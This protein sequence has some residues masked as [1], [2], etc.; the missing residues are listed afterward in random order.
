MEL[1]IHWEKGN[2]KDRGGNN[3]KRIHREAT[4]AAAQNAA[5]EN[6]ASQPRGFGID[7]AFPRKGAEIH[8]LIISKIKLRD[9]FV[10]EWRGG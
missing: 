6:A 3:E 4:H 2:C 5:R 9:A 10:A 7:P 8:H 1:N